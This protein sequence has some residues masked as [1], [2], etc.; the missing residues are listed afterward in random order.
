MQWT[1]IQRSKSIQMVQARMS[2]DNK[3]MDMSD[4]QTCLRIS[5][6]AYCWWLDLELKMTYKFLV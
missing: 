3:C 4:E 2:Q 1:L 6:Q 5:E